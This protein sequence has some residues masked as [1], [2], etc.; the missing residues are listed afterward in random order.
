MD[1]SQA[2]LWHVQCFCLCFVW[3]GG[4]RAS[5]SQPARQAGRSA[6]ETGSLMRH[7]EGEEGRDEEKN[8]RAAEGEPRGRTELRQNLH[9]F[10]YIISS[11]AVISP[12]QYQPP[13]VYPDTST[14]CSGKTNT[15]TLCAFCTHIQN[16]DSS[17]VQ[18]LHFLQ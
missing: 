14:C 2:G 16:S 18:S 9:L 12:S 15:P 11:V 8:Q 13:S 7:Q 5:P 4:L 3:V 1:G 6:A 10:I 17:T